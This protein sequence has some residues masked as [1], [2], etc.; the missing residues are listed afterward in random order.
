MSP[1]HNELHIIGYC[2]ATDTLMYA[3]MQYLD[4]SCI[5]GPNTLQEKF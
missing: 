4:V 5:Y 1:Y 2:I 3:A